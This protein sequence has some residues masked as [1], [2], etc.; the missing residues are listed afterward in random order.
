MH[1]FSVRLVA[2]GFTAALLAAP[3][4]AQ[5]PPKPATKTNAPAKPA[6]KERKGTKWDA[7][8]VGPFFSS[9]IQG[10][11]QTLKGLSIKAGVNATMLFD[12]ELLRMS[13]GWSGGFLLLPTGRDGLEGIPEPVGETVFSVKPGPGWAKGG[14]FD[15]PRP[16]PPQNPRGKPCGPM[17]RDWAHWNGLYLHGT[18]TILSYSV[19]GASVLELP[20]ATERDGMTILTRSFQVEGT[21]SDTGLLV[22]EDSSGTASI[23]G[24]LVMLVK[25]NPTNA[26]AFAAL[27][28]GGSGKWEVSDEAKARGRIQLKFPSLA[29]GKFQVALWSGPKA[30]LPKFIAA[31][32]KLS[33]VPDLKSLTRGGPALWG[34]PLPA[35]GK[36]GKEDAPYVVDTITLP[37]DNPW[38]SWLRLSGF[39]F[40]KNDT[41]AAVCSVS[42]D[43]WLVDGIDDT[44]ENLRW[45]RFATGLFQPL[46]LKIVD[47]KVYVIGRDQLTRLHDLNGDDEADFYENF[48]NDITITPHYHE[49]VL[50]LETDSKGDFYF[51]KGG[52]LGNA[53]IPHHGTL[54][55]VSKDGSKL[56]VVATGLRAPNGM[57]MGPNDEVSTADNEGDWVPTSRVDLAK[58]GGFLGHVF[59]AHRTP[60][61]TTYDPPL[62][63]LPHTYDL[64]NSSGGQVWVTSDKWG[65]FKGHMLH[66]SY[67]ACALFNV[68]QQTVDGVAQA[69]TVKFPLKFDT[70]IMRGRFNRRDGQLYLAGLVVWQSKGP[71]QGGFHRVRYTG[72]PVQMPA[73][74]RVRK[75]GIE[76][77]FTNPLDPA[78]AADAQNYT[79]EQWN[80]RWTQAYG[81]K[82]Y[83]VADPAKQGRDKVEITSA[84]LLPDKKTIF[85]EIPGL[86]PVMQMRIKAALKTAD[87]SP[88]ATEIH[89]TINKVP[90]A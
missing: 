49:F 21:A 51:T 50:N 76:I 68:M 20:A 1:S 54:L 11:H 55:R 48:N 75:N 57:G 35:K 87:G 86:Q 17:P 47:E 81:S 44:L 78:A 77:T 43:V 45:K 72:K 90:G 71:R 4:R 53:R 27:A 80:Y 6:K 69:G 22:H 32:K 70:G 42:G 38:K 74:M 62:F 56:D 46:G 13:A 8:E 65:P 88:L 33:P 7:M 24:N 39:D 61:P 2:L 83:S 58:P 10:K 37:D 3:A 82:D 16:A 9:G 31:A 29:A 84:K 40:F 23:D 14:S 34:A 60:K 41:R 67:G 26:T 25:D 79:I 73:E 89:N 64:D 19:G 18:Q 85:L 12:T 15:D 30:D 5:E 52:D 28:L 36:L 63:W 59:T 66:T